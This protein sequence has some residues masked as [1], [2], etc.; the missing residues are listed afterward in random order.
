M[1]ALR[2]AQRLVG[3]ESVSH[4]SNR[5]VSKYLEMKLNKFGFLVE[6][7]TYRDA[8]GTLKVNLV[9]RK[10]NLPP[11]LEH[12]TSVATATPPAAP[13]NGLAYFCHTDVVPV[14]SW[15]TKEFGPFEPTVRQER[16]YGRGSCDMKGSIA[17]MLAAARKFDWHDLRRP[18]YFVC[19]ADEEVGFHGIR[20][21]V[22]HSQYFRE[23]VNR[24]VPAIIGEPTQLEIVHAHKG[25]LRLVAT[26]RGTAV[27]SST[28]IRTN[29]NLALIPFA[30]EMKEI[31][32]ETEAD[33]RWQNRQFTP[34]TLT[35]NIGLRD[36]ASALNITASESV[37]SVYAR[38]MPDVAFQP[39]LDR[40]AAAAERHGLQLQIIRAC[41]PFW[42]P[43][44]SPFVTAACQLAHR[45]APRTVS[46]ATDGGLLG[47][48]SEKIICGPGGVE[49]AHTHDEWISLEQL[50]RGTE[51]YQKM[52][53]AW[54]CD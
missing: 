17:C 9:A 54:C 15:F 44:D 13:R 19:T 35:W 36:N 5:L 33:P 48:L 37:C 52:I 11:P 8:A 45:A 23:L 24:Q 43:P 22:S 50:A 2:Y 10:G 6:E 34:P 32:E 47:E 28:G 41:E 1:K 4:Q 49:Q 14:T 20:H 53:Q 38:P 31:C 27:H 21:V 46:Y 42:V 29:A 39:L 30:V 25:S 51:L 7:L 26:A 12:T 18:L 3:F 16:L 40:V